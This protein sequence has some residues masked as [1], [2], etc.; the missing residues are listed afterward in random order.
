MLFCFGGVAACAQDEPRAKDFDPV[1]KFGS[2]TKWCDYFAS[3]DPVPNG[4][5]FNQSSP[6]FI[7]SKEVHNYASLWRDHTT[8][9][10]NRDQFIP[11]ILRDLTEL[12]QMPVL[13]LRLGDA[14]LIE[15][16]AARRT[17]RVR[18]LAR[19]RW[20]IWLTAALVTIMRWED[21]PALGAAVFAEL[22]LLEKVLRSVGIGDLTN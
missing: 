21:L 16:A 15:V 8:Y 19:A 13:D 11:L 9:W 14:Q 17:A 1:E 20:A 7:R 22:P 18:W 3:H 5:L 12:S 10:R 6:P 2:R 4:P